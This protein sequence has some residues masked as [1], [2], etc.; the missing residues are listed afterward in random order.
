MECFTSDII[1]QIVFVNTIASLA[2]GATSDVALW[3]CGTFWSPL[4]LGCATFWSPVDVDSG[5]TYGVDA[6]SDS[7]NLLRWA[8]FCRLSHCWSI[9]EPGV[10][11]FGNGRRAL[12]ILAWIL[13][14]GNWLCRLYNVLFQWSWPRSRISWWLFESHCLMLNYPVECLVF[15]LLTLPIISSV[16]SSCVI[17]QIS[18]ICSLYFNAWM[19]SVRTRKFDEQQR[20]AVFFDASALTRCDSW[21]VYQ[22]RLLRWLGVYC[23]CWNDDRKQGNVADISF[24]LHISLSAIK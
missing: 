20:F 16:M 5:S 9:V 10:W 14:I 2:L 1:G 4:A 13:L 6:Q 11:I 3:C 21:F 24:V 12:T 18:F 23:I 15:L 19:S 22:Q 8:V 7:H 17:Y